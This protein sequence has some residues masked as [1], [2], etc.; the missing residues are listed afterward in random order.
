MA[1]RIEKKIKGY[2]VVLPEDKAKEAAAA[3]QASATAD[4]SERPS[5][6]VIQMH[7]RIERPDV[8]IGST[9]K[10]KSPL[11]EHAM[12]VTLNDIVLN[13]GTEHEQRRPFEIFVNSKSME[14]FQWIVALTRIMSAVFRKGGDVTFLV[15]EMKAVFDPRGG[16]FKAG[17][18]YMPSLVAELG[19]IVEEHLKS[20]GMIHDPEMSDAARALI[21]EKRKQYEDR[22]KKNA[23]I[24]ATAPA[25]LNPSPAPAGGGARRADEGAFQ[26]GSDHPEDIAV[27]G[28]GASF[29]PTATMCHKCSTKAVVIM[30]GCATCLNCGYSK[31][32]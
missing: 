31:C 17:G 1:V 23:D 24:S 26:S 18:V 28:D 8:L 7:E 12:Y 30:D 20:I 3:A 14:H 25:A 9:Y 10:I 32:G 11:V 5:A 21:A 19:S 29:P 4:S 27:T 22:S 13:A 2:A 6:D 15:E 16:Y